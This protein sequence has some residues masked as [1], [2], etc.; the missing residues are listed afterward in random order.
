MVFTINVGRIMN[1][2]M[3]G[4]PLIVC[5]K[6]R[7]YE[8]EDSFFRFFQIGS[9]RSEEISNRLELKWMT[10]YDAPIPFKPTTLF[11]E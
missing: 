4:F 3:S 9:F 2:R 11:T 6:L 10:N 8:G 7:I 1:F 5:I